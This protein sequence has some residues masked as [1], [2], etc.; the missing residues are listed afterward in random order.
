MGPACWVRASPVTPT[1]LADPCAHVRGTTGFTNFGDV[2][3]PNVEESSEVVVRS[4]EGLRA[5]IRDETLPRTR[6][7]AA[8]RADCHSV[9]QRGPE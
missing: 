2:P 8:M 3:S 9:G 1:R 5:R 6:P 4:G 7:A